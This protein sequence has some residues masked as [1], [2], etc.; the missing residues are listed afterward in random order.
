MSPIY[1]IAMNTFKEALRYRILYLLLIFAI[2]LIAFSKLLGLLTVGA[3]DKVIKDLG[4]AAI[5]F[6][7]ILSSI[8]VGIHL[9]SSEIEKKTIYTV[10][11]KPVGR[12][13]FI[14]GK[15]FG[16]LFTL[17][18]NLVFMTA[19]F[20]FVL[21]VR[22]G[23]VDLGLLK[24]TLLFYFEFMVVTAFAIFFS[25]FTSPILSAV[26]SLLMYF[27]GH[28]SFGLK[29]FAANEKLP[30]AWKGVLS[31][32]YYIAP[33]LE[34]FNVKGEA[35]YG[36]PISLGFIFTSG[37]YGIAYSSAILLF[38]ILIFNKRDFT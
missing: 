19:V 35:V 29:E 5:S 10:I 13:Q 12:H 25:S 11:S 9:V 33:N 28:L 20:Y 16:L 3:E 26:L 27:I 36:D 31:F 38:S 15:Y 18:T 37:A 24:A 6:F 8:F 14:L 34:S 21:Y 22:I 23:V 2:I 32:L 7:G 17:L 30:A 4:L 1:A